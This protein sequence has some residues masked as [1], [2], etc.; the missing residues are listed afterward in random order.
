MKA[1]VAVAL[2][3]LAC[4]QSSEPAGP[5]TQGPQ[6]RCEI[7]VDADTWVRGQP[8]N[9]RIAVINFL[10]GDLEM[11]VLASL[12]LSDAADDQKRPK[13][14][15]GRYWSPL[16]LAAQAREP[17]QSTP[18]EQ[19]RVTERKPVQLKI[20]GRGKIEFSVDAAAMEWAPLISPAWPH[21]KLF[22]VVPNGNYRL[23]ASLSARGH[24]VKS[25]AVEISIKK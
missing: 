12:E 20:P 4:P 3:L 10:E 18:R 23:W 15:S 16:D 7:R 2:A 25:N 24:D 14:A 22:A 17:G 19:A 11:A 9:V 6:A 1:G 8:G 5:G 21:Q 13:Q